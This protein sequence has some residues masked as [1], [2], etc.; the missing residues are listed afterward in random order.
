M[1]GR[2]GTGRQRRGNGISRRD[3]WGTPLTVSTLLLSAAL[4][5]GC[6]SASSVA[7]ND[8]GTTTPDAAVAIGTIVRG[9]SQPCTEAHSICVNAKFPASMTV[10]PKKVQIDF[11]VDIPPAHPPDGIPLAIPTP[12]IQAGETV[13]LRMTDIGLTGSYHF[14]GLVFMPGGG[15]FF[16]VAGVDY[17]GDSSVAYPLTG[18]A[19]NLP[20]TLDFHYLQ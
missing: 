6:G 3:G 2:D 5:G 9:T 4:A 8:G 7:G 1:R 17:I 14:L 19:L 20:E 11:Y 13:Q 12:D 10:Q 18:A 15:D 16:P